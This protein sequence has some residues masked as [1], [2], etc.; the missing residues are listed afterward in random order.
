[1][2]LFIQVLALLSTSLFLVA[3]FLLLGIESKSG[4]SV[5]EVFYHYIGVISFGF[6]VFTGGLLIA[7][8]E[9]VGGK[10]WN[11]IR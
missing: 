8:A 11:P 3:G 5:A 4:E 10:Q 2:K 9:K 6:S 7:L 1:M